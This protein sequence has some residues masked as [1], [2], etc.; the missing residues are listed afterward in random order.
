[1]PDA[2]KVGFVPFSSAPR[3]VLVVRSGMPKDAGSA[4]AILAAAW[5]AGLAGVAIDGPDPSQDVLARLRE[6]CPNG[7]FIVSSGRPEA[8]A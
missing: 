8:I 1:M 3:G 5:R 4:D 2:V 6:A 7:R